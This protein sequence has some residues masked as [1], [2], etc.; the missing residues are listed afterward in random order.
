MQAQAEG[1]TE[2]QSTGDALQSLFSGDDGTINFFL[3]M[4]CA[5]ETMCPIPPGIDEP[6]YASYPDFP[7]ALLRFL[8]GEP[9]GAADGSQTEATPGAVTVSDFETVAG[10]CS[11]SLCTGS[12]AAAALSAALGAVVALA[13][14]CVM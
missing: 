2:D 11:T 8:D 5:L 6:E 13:F 4:G 3:H 14:L 9:D 12:A 10:C 7:A 1:E